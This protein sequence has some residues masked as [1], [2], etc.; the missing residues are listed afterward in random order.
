MGGK[1]SDQAFLVSLTMGSMDLTFV[2]AFNLAN[3]NTL[4]VKIIS[5]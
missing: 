1:V 3:T 2:V 4:L 5:F